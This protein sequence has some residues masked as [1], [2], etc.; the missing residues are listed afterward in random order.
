MLPPSSSDD[1]DVPVNDNADTAAP[2]DP[3][4]LDIARAIGR[5]IA[6][7]QFRKQGAVND[8]DDPELT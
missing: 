3:R 5:F 7:E 1:R 2:L 8:N 6:R 4:I